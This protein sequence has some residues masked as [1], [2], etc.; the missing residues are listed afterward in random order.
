MERWRIA[1]FG[2]LRVQRAEQVIT[3]FKSQKVAGL[4]AYLAYHVRQAHP[5]EVLIDI[6]WPDSE[7]DAGRASLSRSAASLAQT[8]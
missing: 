3:R 7:I 1:L 6:F 2:G 8:A 4:L 5:R